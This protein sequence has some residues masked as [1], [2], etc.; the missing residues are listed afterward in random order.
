MLGCR[1]CFHQW[2]Q[3]QVL[4]PNRIRPDLALR[5]RD[6]GNMDL[7]ITYNDPEAYNKSWTVPFQVRLLADDEM[8]ETVCNENERDRDHMVGKGEERTVKVAPATLSKYVGTYQLRG[9]EI[10]ISLNGD[11]LM[12]DNGGMGQFPINA[13]TET[14][15]LFEPPAQGPP[16]KFEFVKDGSGAV[17]ALIWHTNR[18]DA[19]RATRK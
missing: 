17:N 15:F 12:A 8:L 11:Q 1:Q 6:F 18:G 19:L 16:S 10:V 13:E 14:L 2:A 4:R 9:R 7:Q 3:L 5:R